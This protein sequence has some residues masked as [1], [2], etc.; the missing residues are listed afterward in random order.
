MP[1]TFSLRNHLI[2]S[3]SDSAWPHSCS[4]R[5]PAPPVHPFSPPV[6]R[7]RAERIFTEGHCCSSPVPQSR[8]IVLVMG[9]LSLSALGCQSEELA[10]A[11]QM[12]DDEFLSQ[13]LIL[14]VQTLYN[15]QTQV[16]WAAVLWEAFTPCLMCK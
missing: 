15:P 3:S 16:E 4:S 10:K 11:F 14:Q 9:T 13:S 1:W 12:G 8:E 7:G 2:F 6:Q 5:Q